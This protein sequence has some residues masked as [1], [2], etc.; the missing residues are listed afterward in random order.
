MIEG[1]EENIDAR[2]DE[3]FQVLH[4]ALR[5]AVGGEEKEDREE[6]DNAGS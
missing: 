2:L 6:A 1:G 3:Q 5:A 4:A